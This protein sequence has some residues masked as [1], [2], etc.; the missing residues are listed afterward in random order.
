MPNATEA[1]VPHLPFLRRY[2][3][4]LTGSQQ[5]GDEYVVAS[6][7]AIIEEVDDERLVAQPRLELFRVFHD[8]W[9][10]L[11]P[12]TTRK[13][14]AEGDEA[15]GQVR[16]ALAAMP[17]RN[18]QAFL[19]AELE[20]FTLQEIAAILRT[21]DGEVK[22]LL[23]EARKEL[24]EQPAARVLIVEDD[25]V[26]SLG[27]A[28]IV[29]EMGHKVAATARTAEE[30]IAAFEATQPDLI[31]ADIRLAD[32]SSG[33]DAVARILRHTDVPVVYVT[34]HP[35]DVLTGKQVEPTYVIE[36]PFNPETLKAAIAQALSFRNEELQTA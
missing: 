9:A 6:L 21:N 33:L 7:E 15:A 22:S 20:R 12:P 18:R 30:A 14:L 34:G 17:R 19:L 28:A 24:G 10:R 31:L 27:N 2:A 16:R 32:G 11:A 23:S 36:K 13:D 35:E 8:V 25:P 29:E 5:R 3:R 26:I 4:A 1:L